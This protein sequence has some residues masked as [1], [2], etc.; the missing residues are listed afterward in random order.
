MH[1]DVSA[2][3]LDVVFTSPTKSSSWENSGESVSSLGLSS[4]ARSAREEILE[5]ACPHLDFRPKLDRPVSRHLPLT[6]PYPSL[7]WLEWA[8]TLIMP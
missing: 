8:Q 2:V 7:P 3:V 6:E 5:K 4:E 1:D